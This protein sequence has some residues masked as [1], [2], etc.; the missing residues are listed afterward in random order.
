MA[1]GG[2]LQLEDAHQDMLLSVKEIVKFPSG[3][4]GDS[5]W[6]PENKL[7]NLHHHVLA[8]NTVLYPTVL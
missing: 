2:K 1:P 6:V 3:P 7:L 8:C 5:L 4:S